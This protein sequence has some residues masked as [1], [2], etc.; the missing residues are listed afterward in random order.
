LIFFRAPHLQA[1]WDFIRGIFCGQQGNFETGLGKVE[2]AFSMVLITIMLVIE[3][4]RAGY[5]VEN[6]TRF[7][8]AFASM[9]I[10]CYL[11]GVFSENQFIYF[12][13]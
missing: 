7:Y 12:Q 1:A 8:L 6:N 11:F 4:F 5:E 9:V 2:L 10:I 13:F 3:K